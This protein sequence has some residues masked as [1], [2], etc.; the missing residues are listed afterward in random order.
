MP[1]PEYGRLFLELEVELLLERERKAFRLRADLVDPGPLCFFCLFAREQLME[2]AVECL[3][4]GEPLN[5][6]L[7]A[8]LTWRKPPRKRGPVAKRLRVGPQ[9]PTHDTNETTAPSDR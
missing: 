4:A 6:N 1:A 9:H 7:L 2:K 8:A 3:A 5:D